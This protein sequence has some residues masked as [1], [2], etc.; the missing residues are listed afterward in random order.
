MPVHAVLIATLDRTNLLVRAL[1]SISIQTCKPDRIVIVDD[2]REPDIEALER[3]GTE[4]DLNLEILANR[5]TFGA[6][7]AWNTGLDH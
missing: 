3:I 1:K 7:G 6:S 5:R 4:F 2:S